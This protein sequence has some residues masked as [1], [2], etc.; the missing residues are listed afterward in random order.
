MILTYLK[1]IVFSI[2]F[3][4]LTISAFSQRDL[5]ITQAGEEIR[6]KILDETPTR[7]IYAYIGPKD[8]VL[9]NEIFKNLVESFKYSHY[10]TDLLKNDK[11]AAK[12]SIST[13]SPRID[14]RKS[15]TKSPPKRDVKRNE[16]DDKSKEI[17]IVPQNEKNTSK[18]ENKENASK[19][20]SSSVPTKET[21]KE[22]DV[23]KEIEKEANAESKNLEKDSL[24]LNTV[25]DKPMVL[26][27]ENS[28]VTEVIKESVKQEARN[29]D[30]SK[31]GDIKSESEK[32]I[33]KKDLSPLADPEIKSEF[34][35]FM[36]F[37]VGVKG[38]LGNIIQKNTDVSPFGLFKEKLQRGWMFGVDAAFFVN[39]HF[40]FGA[41]YTNFQ[42]SN[43]SKKLDYQ[44]L[45]NGEAIKDGEL[46]AKVS[47]KFVGPTFLYRKAI[48]FKTFAVLTLSPG[49]HLYTDKGITNAANYKFNGQ[50]YGAAATLG[51]D[52]LLGNDIFGRD[53][54]LSLEGGYN[55]GQI[56]TLNK[57]D[58]L[59]KITLPS[60]INLNRLDFTIGLRFTRFPMYLR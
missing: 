33:S 17:K 50:A 2:C 11:L 54:I 40:G 27:K 31:N 36:K 46:D 39:D 43:S 60:P 24:I 42:A 30:E 12:P 37:R 56:A 3:L 5:I 51:L 10:N 18:I 15:E 57:G 55:Y 8:K 35:N 47:H 41:T 28:K 4:F 9:R 21:K 26:P 38:G 32:E 16:E 19:M 20:N 22:K 58:N 48:D 45:F 53:I 14:T 1:N 7:F 59:G 6:C 52:F 44:N 29:D 13:A 49:M 23:K 25:L 34:K